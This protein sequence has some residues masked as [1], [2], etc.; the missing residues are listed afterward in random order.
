MRCTPNDDRFMSPVSTIARLQ[1]LN[2]C[3]IGVTYL[4][5]NALLLPKL[6]EFLLLDHFKQRLLYR[7]ANQHFQHWYHFQIK[8][9][10]LKV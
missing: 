3:K 8:V 10:E 6:L 7:L 1:S 4:H 5:L 2:F 9:K